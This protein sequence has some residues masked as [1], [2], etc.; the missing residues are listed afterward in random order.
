MIFHGI[1]K[2][3]YEI[4]DSSKSYNRVIKKYFNRKIEIYLKNHKNDDILNIADLIVDIKQNLLELEFSEFDIDYFFAGV[5]KKFSM[6]NESYSKSPFTFYDTEIEHLIIELIIMKIL[7]YI[8]GFDI[9]PIIVQMRKNNLLPDNLLIQIQE[10]KKKYENDLNKIQNLKKYLSIKNRI[11]ETL[12]NNQINFSNIQRDMTN[13]RKLQLIYLLFRLIEYINLERK[14]D[15]H[16]I[17]DFLITHTKEY[18]DT[19]P[20]V[21]LKNPELYY[22]GIYLSVK[23]DLPIDYVVLN[24]FLEQVYQDLINSFDA[25]FVQ[26]T[27][28]IY[29]L[30]KTLDLIGSTLSDEKINRLMVENDEF[31]R[32][33]YLKDLET[34]RIIL[35]SKIY[36]YLGIRNKINPLKI[37][38]IEDEINRRVETID[39]NLNYSEV[40]YYLIFHYY[41]TGSLKNL[42]NFDIINTLVKKIHQNLTI[43][44][45][46]DETSNDIISELVYSF[47]C[48]KLLNCI[49]TKESFSHLVNYFL[50]N[51]AIAQIQQDLEQIPEISNCKQLKINKI[52]GDL[53]IF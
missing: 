35:I 40:L 5:E 27:R 22:C 10:L 30:I 17:K 4:L 25:P 9:N 53:N 47:E 7:E 31:Y 11:I 21:T 51:Q 32:P 26:G 1:F 50:P 14:F 8:V 45:L 12:L 38:A 48:L 44:I 46:N 2:I 52:T 18:L 37:A 36:N 28:R 20:L 43:L 6:L 19:I 16:H 29:Y 24:F 41:G 34:S 49:N 15:F 3:I 42:E 39:N 13:Y 23:L 33:D